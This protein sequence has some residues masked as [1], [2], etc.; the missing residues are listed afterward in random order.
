VVMDGRIYIV[1][2]YVTIDA[3]TETS[4]R[5]SDVYVH[6][7]DVA[8]D[9][10]SLV[11]ANSSSV[12]LELSWAVPTAYTAASSTVGGSCGN[13]QPLTLFELEVISRDEIEMIGG[14]ANGSTTLL[15][16]GSTTL[17]YRGAE[18][19][20]T[21]LDLTPG[22]SYSFRV[23]AGSEM[24]TSLPALSVASVLVPYSGVAADPFSLLADYTTHRSLSALRLTPCVPTCPR[25]SRCRLHEL[26]GGRH[27]HDAHG[28][29]R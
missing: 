6:N 29:T 3:A 24:G 21:V 5:S 16:R 20:F 28:D 10:P 22:T 19:A 12:S 27:A 25:V 23:R 1:G 8:L 11:S 9:A 14:G 7:A 15:Y 4:E 18:S 13:L 17:L 2:G 26:V